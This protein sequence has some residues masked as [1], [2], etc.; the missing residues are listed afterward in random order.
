MKCIWEVHYEVQWHSWEPT[1]WEHHVVKVCTGPD[2]MEAVE[3]AR[4]AALNAHRLDDRGREERCSHFRLR[5][6][7]LLA[8]AQL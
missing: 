2:A 1:H 4:K 7:K 5:D 6:V 3:I 8:E